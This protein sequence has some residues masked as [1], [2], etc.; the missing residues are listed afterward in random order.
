MPLQVSA[1]IR[2]KKQKKHVLAEAAVEQIGA[3]PPVAQAMQDAAATETV[4]H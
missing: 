2:R 3:A 4:Q 1:K